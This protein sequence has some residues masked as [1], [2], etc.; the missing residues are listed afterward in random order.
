MSDEHD[1]VEATSSYEAT[2]LGTVAPTPVPAISSNS[3]ETSKKL[4]TPTAAGSTYLEVRKIN[5]TALSLL[6]WIIQ[7]LSGQL[8]GPI[9][10][11][12]ATLVVPSLT[13]VSVAVFFTRKANFEQNVSLLRLNA[14]A[15]TR[16]SNRFKAF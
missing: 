12:V 16:F 10:N 1:I 7:S 6:C 8:W 15:Q 9:I 3:Q 13:Y 11:I 2:T 4:V 5:F 14:K